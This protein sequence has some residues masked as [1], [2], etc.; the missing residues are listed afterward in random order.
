MS[1]E[2]EIDSAVAQAE[3]F[4]PSR[5]MP[6]DRVNALAIRDNEAVSRRK[7]GQN[8]T[9]ARESRALELLVIGATYAQIAKQLNMKTASG[10]R[11][12]VLRALEKR[13]AESRMS[14]DSA[15]VIFTE[16]LELLYRRWMPIALGANGG[17]PDSRAAKIVLDALA[18]FSEVNGLKTIHIEHEQTVTIQSADE[19]RAAVVASIVDYANRGNTIEGETVERA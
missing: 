10:A 14:T 5:E 2:D 15:R 4:G 1:I 17:E 6:L 16:R 12:L 18:R 7:L 11:Q 9:N 8:A 19:K 3:E 13:A